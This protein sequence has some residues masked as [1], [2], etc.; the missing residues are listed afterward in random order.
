MP[1]KCLPISLLLFAGIAWSQ[2]TSG[3]IT[4]TVLDAQSA[5]IPGAT[6]TAQEAQQKFV[7]TGK[8][9][10][11]GTFV[12]T[13]VPPGTYTIKVEAS[14]FKALE[15]AG[16]VLNA[17]DKMAVGDLRMAIG[18]AS[19]SI[20]ISARMLTLP[21]LETRVSYMARSW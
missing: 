21:S 11:S 20:E 13:A 12:F 17:N 2:T 10:E 3:S 15:Q 5:V 16:L 1:K 6:V 19:E 18:A 14:G 4:G 7:F 8:T 9:N